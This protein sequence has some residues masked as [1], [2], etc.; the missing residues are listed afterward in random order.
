MR[1]RSAGLAPGG[2][3]GAS[4]PSTMLGEEPMGRFKAAVATVTA[5]M[6][7]ERPIVEVPR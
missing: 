1:P 5:E 3:T 7:Q 2:T 4:N 6:P